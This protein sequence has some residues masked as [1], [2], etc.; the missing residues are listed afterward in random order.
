MNPEI[1]NQINELQSR[2]LQLR[3]IMASSDDRAAKCVKTGLS[4]R[5]TYPDDFVR[6]QAANDEYNRNEQT[7]AELE[8]RAS[9]QQ[10]LPRDL[11]AQRGGEKQ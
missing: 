7:L 3:A 9:E 8:A 5:E 1:I 10:D 6:Y 11:N 2:Q 4:F